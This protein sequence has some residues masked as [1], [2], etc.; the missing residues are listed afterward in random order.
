MKKKLSKDDI[1]KFLSIWGLNIKIYNKPAFE[2]FQ[3][4]LLY[5]KN[6]YDWSLAIYCLRLS[7]YNLN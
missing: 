5:L 6:E 3:S 7:I 1:I 4:N 2:Y